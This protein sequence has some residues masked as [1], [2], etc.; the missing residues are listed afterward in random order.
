MQDPQETA[1]AEGDPPPLT[2]LPHTL[3]MAPVPSP[4]QLVPFYDP[5][6]FEVFVKEWVPALDTRY[7]LVERHGGS[8][9][10]GIDVAGYLSAHRLE[11]Q[12]HNYQCKRYSAA[13]TWS[14]AAQEMRKMFVA[15]AAGHFTVPTRYV[16]VAPKIARSL[17]RLL[18]KPTDSKER[19]LQDLATAKEKVMSDLLPHELAAVKTLAA[20][21]DFSMFEC[22]DLDE[23][24]ELH[25]TTAHWAERFPHAQLAHGPQVILPPDEHGENEH[26]YVQCLLDVYREK[27]PDQISTLQQVPDVADADE[28]LKRQR[29]AFYTAEALRLFARDATTPAYFEQVK[30]DVYD[31]VVEVAVCAYPNGWE[32]HGAVTTAASAVHLTPTVLTPYVQPKARKG[33][34]HHLANDNRLTWCQKEEQ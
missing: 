14:T 21:A 11:G 15:A 2:V 23:M 25:S 19:F 12:W 31:I 33:V 9:D 3:R 26:R 1:P 18:A 16:F 7:T 28:H 34:C 5:D 17:P 6:E 13:L 24:L 22:V 27:F 4:K 29:E 8:G 30:Q 32:R 10:H 20:A